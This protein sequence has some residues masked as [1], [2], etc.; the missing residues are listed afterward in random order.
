VKPGGRKVQAVREMKEPQNIKGVRQFLGLSGYFRRHVENNARIVEPLTRL[1]RKD[2]PWCWGSEQQSAF[3][4]IKTILTERPVLAVFD[5]K[6]ETELHTDASSLGYGA[7]LMQR[8]GELSRV[9]AYYS[10][11]STREQKYYHSY[12]LETLAVVSALRYFRVYLIGIKFRVVTDC[13]ALRT[14]FAKK[15]LLPSMARWWLEVQDYTF[16]IT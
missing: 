8:R 4:N 15:D 16:E 10:K 2:T 5:P 7:I 6:L 1:L 12:E 3:D 11:Q 14:T 9:V 13:S